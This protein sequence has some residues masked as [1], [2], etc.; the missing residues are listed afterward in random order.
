MSKRKKLLVGYT[1][2]VGSNLKNQ[3]QFDA[4]ACSSNISTFSGK[5]FDEVVVAAGDARKWYANLHENEDFAHINSLLDDVT[6]IKTNKLIHFSTVDV[7]A[8]KQGSEN[9]LKGNVSKEPYG[10]HR[11]YLE[12]SLAD[13]FDDVTTIRLPGLYGQGLKKNIIFD[14]L[15]N[16]SLEAFNSNSRFQWFNLKNLSEIMTVIDN[17]SIKEIN[18]CSEPISVRELLYSLGVDIE[19]NDHSNAIVDYD[20]TSIYAEKFSNKKYL[21]TKLQA[22]DSI[23]TFCSDWN[24]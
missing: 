11:Y 12:K 24:S 8:N 7:Y 21:Y 4:Y 1:G 23:N 2:F 17:F 19:N 14:Y 20:I 9:D 5:S 16:K 15:N 3:T 22:L 6:K 18:V 13:Y 10:K